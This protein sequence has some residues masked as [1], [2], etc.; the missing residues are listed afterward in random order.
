MDF[1]LPQSTAFLHNIPSG[2]CSGSRLPSR[3]GQRNQ[4]LSCKLKGPFVWRCLPSV[5]MLAVGLL[6]PPLLRNPGRG[7]VFKAPHGGTPLPAAPY[8]LPDDRDRPYLKQEP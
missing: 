1:L 7:V 3:S 6:A 8:L 2:N 5:T 4:L